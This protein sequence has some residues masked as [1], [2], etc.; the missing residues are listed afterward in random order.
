MIFSYIKK[1]N[2]TKITGVT[3]VKISIKRIHLLLGR[4]AES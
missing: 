1:L 4:Q 3:L 2:F